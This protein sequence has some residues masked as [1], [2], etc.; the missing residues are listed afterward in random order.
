MQLF[1]VFVSI[2][3]VI[4]TIAVGVAFVA[5]ATRDNAPVLFGSAS[6]PKDYAG[7]APGAD[8]PLPTSPAVEPASPA[9]QIVVTGRPVVQS[10]LESRNVVPQEVEAAPLASPIMTGSIDQ[11]STEPDLDPGDAARRERAQASGEPVSRSSQRSPSR[12]SSD[13]RWMTNFFD[14]Q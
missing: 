2:L 1:R 6:T 9:A 14:R 13:R 11:S 8:A 3:A 5:P 12:P 4:A 10:E 7:S